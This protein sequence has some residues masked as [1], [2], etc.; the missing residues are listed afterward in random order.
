MSVLAGSEPPQVARGSCTFAPAAGSFAEAE[1]V[2]GEEE[3]EGGRGWA[4]SWTTL[5]GLAAATLTTITDATVELLHIVVS[6]DP[7]S[8]DGRHHGQGT[9]ELQEPRCRRMESHHHR[10]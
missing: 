9:S 7:V 5:L 8:G 2:E 10:W 6:L 4:Q 3:E 1:L